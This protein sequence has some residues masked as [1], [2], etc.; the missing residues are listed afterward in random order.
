M[1]DKNTYDSHTISRDDINLDGLPIKKSKDKNGDVLRDKFDGKGKLI[2]RE[3]MAYNKKDKTTSKVVT[4]FIRNKGGAIIERDDS[5]YNASGELTKR[6]EHVITGRGKSAIT[7]VSEC[8]YGDGYVVLKTEKTLNSSGGILNE[9]EQFFDQKG[10]ILIEHSFLYSNGILIAIN[11][12]D[13]TLN[14]D[15]KINYSEIKHYDGKEELISFSKRKY[16]NN[17]GGDGDIRYEERKYNNNDELVEIVILSKSFNADGVSYNVCEE[18]YSSEQDLN[19]DNEFKVIDSDFDVSGNLI[20]S[21]TTCGNESTRIS[22]EFDSFGKLKS[23]VEKVSLTHHGLTYQ[24]NIYT[25]DAN[26]VEIDVVEITHTYDYSSRK[27][28]SSYEF[29]RTNDSKGQM[30]SSIE[31][32]KEYD[33][34]GNLISSVEDKSDP[35]GEL[36]SGPTKESISSSENKVTEHTTVTQKYNDQTIGKF[37]KKETSDVDGNFTEINK[38]IY[39][40]NGIRIKSVTIS[41]KINSANNRTYLAEEIQEFGYDGKFIVKVV[42][43][44]EFKFDSDGKLL[45]QTQSTQEFNSDGVLTF[46]SGGEYKADGHKTKDFSDTSGHDGEHRHLEHQYETLD[47]LMSSMNG[48]DLNEGVPT[49]VDTHFIPVMKSNTLVA[50]V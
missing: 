38:D 28:Q 46:C 45:S 30:T 34:N 13:N 43:S 18:F 27:L 17:S 50:P 25:Y 47:Y 24:E 48:F 32:R 41:E 39:D 6:K 31:I 2:W 23:K 36:V 4:N 40:E 10:N 21:D 35:A 11:K 1:N 7:R 9:K 22:Q 5:T 44:Y 20:Y 8:Q 12:Q 42:D 37:T 26:G 33:S 15:N 29:N 3:R 14:I 19:N 49:S 16:I